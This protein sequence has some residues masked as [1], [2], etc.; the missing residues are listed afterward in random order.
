MYKHILVATDC[1]PLAERGVRSAIELAAFHRATLTGLLVVPDYTTHEFAES[2]LVTGQRPEALRQQLAEAGRARLDRSLEAVPG[3]Q[4][5]ER[6]VAVGDSPA[7]EIVDC[8]ERRS[9]DLIV[10]TSHGRAALSSAL[11]GSQTIRVLALSEIPVLVA[12]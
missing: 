4:S 1:S 10:M 9:C 5:I 6:V 3:S 7:Q 12:R 8:A 11:L 2:V